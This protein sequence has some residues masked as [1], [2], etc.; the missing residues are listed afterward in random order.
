MKIFLTFTFLILNI[1]SGHCFTLLAQSPPRYTVDEVVFNVANDDCTTIGIT[2]ESLLDLVEQ[3]MDIYWNSVPTSRIKFIRGGVST[4][5][6]N[7]ETSVGDLITNSGTVNT[8]IVGCNNDFGASAGQGGYAYSGSNVYGGLLINDS[9]QVAALT[10]AQKMAVIAHEIGHAFGLGHSNFDAALMH[11][12][13]N[14]NISLLGRDDED[15]ITYLYPNTQK[16]GGCGTIEIVSNDKN[17]DGGLKAVLS[18]TLILGFIRLFGMGF[19]YLRP[20]KNLE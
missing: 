11:Y 15:G 12:S 17:N 10:D 8:I 5:S 2:A 6:A 9:A 14:S 16:V 13:L 1:N 18:F 3:S 4:S 7:G 19:Q 20:K